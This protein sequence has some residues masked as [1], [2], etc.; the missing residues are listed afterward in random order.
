MW[1][2]GILSCCAGKPNHC[3]GNIGNAGICWLVSE[4]NEAQPN[5]PYQKHYTKSHTHFSRPLA[6][7]LAWLVSIIQD[8]VWYPTAIRP[9]SSFTARRTFSKLT[10]KFCQCGAKFDKNLAGSTA[11]LRSM[12]RRT[13]SLRRWLHNTY[14]HN[15]G[16]C[17]R[18]SRRSL[19]KTCPPTLAD[20]SLGFVIGFYFGG[21]IP[22][23][24]SASL[25]EYGFSIA[26]FIFLLW[27]FC[28]LCSNSTAFEVKYL[29]H[30]RQ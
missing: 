20:D 12:S 16:H 6:S 8:S 2:K 24:A 5:S 7:Q 26:N 18:R 3:P 23:A 4:K 1:E 17:S 15:E 10:A 25:I 9:S 30:V 29:A 11:K 14:T 13:T 28:L 22:A 21:A 19:A 27:A